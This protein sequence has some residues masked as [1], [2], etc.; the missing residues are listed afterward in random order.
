[1]LDENHGILVSQSGLDQ[2]LDVVGRGRD[3]Y[4]QAWN[5]SKKRPKGVGMMRA[6]AANTTTGGTQHEGHFEPAVRD[7]VDGG[8]LLHDLSHG[9]QSE[10]H[11]H[12]VHDGMT[13]RQCRSDAKSCL[14]A[15]RDGCVAHPRFAEFIPQTAALLEVTAS[16]PNAL[17]YI[18]DVGIAPHLFANAFH[19]GLGVGEDAWVSAEGSTAGGVASFVSDILV[20]RLN[21]HIRGVRLCFRPRARWPGRTALRLPTPPQFQHQLSR[22]LRRLAPWPR[23]RRL[24]AS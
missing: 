5:M 22:S 17:P 11:E 12:D 23:W 20:S 7:V 8:G 19:A 21:Q 9:L 16:W 15:F 6:G 3:G 24:S 18:K 13:A 1:M 2:P 10:I 4:L 14:R